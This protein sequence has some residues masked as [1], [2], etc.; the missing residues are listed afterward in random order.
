MRRHGRSADGGASRVHTGISSITPKRAPST[1]QVQS[2]EPII[3]PQGL[4]EYGD[5]S[6]SSETADTFQKFQAA[7]IWPILTVPL[8]GLTNL[9]W[10]RSSSRNLQ[11]VDLLMIKSAYTEEVA[12]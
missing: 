2:G 6:P 10:R 4:L 12:G 3:V 11:W 9:W 1:H 7:R 5:S 8:R